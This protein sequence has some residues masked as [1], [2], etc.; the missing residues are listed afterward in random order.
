[1]PKATSKILNNIAQAPS[2][3]KSRSVENVKFADGVLPPAELETLYHQIVELYKPVY[4][5]RHKKDLTPTS[6]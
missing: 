1:M 2:P 3:K 6:M 4:E 5:M